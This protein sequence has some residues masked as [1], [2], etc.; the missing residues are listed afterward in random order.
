MFKEIDVLTDLILS[1]DTGCPCWITT[2]YPQ[3][4][5]KWN[6]NDECESIVWKILFIYSDEVG[7]HMEID[8]HIEMPA[9]LPLSR[10]VGIYQIWF[11]WG[12]VHFSFTACGGLWLSF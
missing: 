9:W 10:G 8:T 5:C 11:I 6:T 2:L 4:A 7:A 3:S 1:S 12:F